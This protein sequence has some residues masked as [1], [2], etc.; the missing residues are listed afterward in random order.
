MD[1][2]R[3]TTSG[4]IRVS[5]PVLRSHAGRWDGASH[6]LQ[7]QA[8]LVSGLSVDAATAGPFAAFAPGYDGLIQQ[9]RD[10]LVEGA[11]AAAQIAD[12]LVGVANDYDSHDTEHRHTLKMLDED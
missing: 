12:T 1:T 5:T 7:G 3:R 11:G 6:L 8:D 9:L 2:G 4:R 10:R